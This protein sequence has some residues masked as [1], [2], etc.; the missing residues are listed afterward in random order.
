MRVSM[1]LYDN[2]KEKEKEKIVEIQIH[3]IELTMHIFIVR[4]LFEN[5]SSFPMMQNVRTQARIDV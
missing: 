3:F 5:A 1:W 2:K 4:S